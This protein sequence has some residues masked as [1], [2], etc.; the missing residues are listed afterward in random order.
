MIGDA[1]NSIFG[2]AGPETGSSMSHF[3]DGAPSDRAGHDLQ[4]LSAPV[5]QSQSRWDAGWPIIDSCHRTRAR[6]APVIQT[7]WRSSGLTLIASNTVGTDR[8]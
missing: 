5:A 4:H 1:N 6:S 8:F 2:A 7:G 3:G